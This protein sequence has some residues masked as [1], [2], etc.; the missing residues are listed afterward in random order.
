[1]TQKKHISDLAILGGSKLFATCKPTSNLVRPGFETFL[2]YS[3]LFFEQRQYTNN[4]PCVKLLE[5]RLAEF[6]QTQFC[7]AFC[8]GFWALALT[9]KSLAL[10]GK[11][12][13]I[14]PSLT[15][16]RMADIAA[17]A[18]LT[19]HFCD[20][21]PHSLAM[22]TESVLPCIN[23]K[24]AIILAVHPI[25][26]CCDV[27]DLV[28]LTDNYHIPL[29]FDS[30]ESVYETVAG[31]KVGSFGEAEVFS[32]H[33]SK[34]LNGFE[35]G[36]VS[37]N[38]KKLRAQLATIRTFG[39]AGIDNISTAGGM[40]AKLNEVHASMALAS[41]D[42]VEEQVLQNRERYYT[43]KKELLRI[44]GLRL[45]EFDESFQTGFK[46]IVVEL[47]DEWPLS[48]ADTL[49][50]MNAENILSRAYYS[51]LLHKKSTTYPIV[52]KELPVS[53][54]LSISFMNLP[55]GYFVSFEDIREIVKFLEFLFHHADCI[56]DLLIEKKGGD[57]A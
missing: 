47:L 9:I 49:Q 3:K 35:G 19:P 32:L 37:T 57:N 31:G 4:G 41:L 48:R 16:R 39:F 12:E 42:N 46:N 5:K 54:A 10:E 22:S 2:K 53:D 26:N 44:S 29:L 6:H 51:P 38:S 14:M 23:D 55:C 33:A 56:H 20:V 21:D 25:V 1:M 30:V 8:S 7:V 18:G 50:I 27:E 43:Y 15:Y 11:T 40:N 36:Y 45:L 52:T 17:W 34:L 13:I 28:S 24:T